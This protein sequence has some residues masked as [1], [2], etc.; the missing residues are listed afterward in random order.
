MIARARRVL[1][2]MLV[3]I[4]LAGPA[5]AASPADMS[6]AA[7]AGATPLHKPH[8]AAAKHA[9]APDHRRKPAAT[10]AA[11]RSASPAA[12]TV[13]LVDDNF[14]FTESPSG[15]PGWKQSGVASWYG[16]TRWQGHMT[17]RGE[18]YDE[19]ALTAAHATLPLGSKV[20]VKLHNSDRFV[21]VT[22]TDRPGT[23]VRIIDLS[24]GAARALGIIAQGV[25]MVTLTPL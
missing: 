20:R 12:D 11:A 9:A 8:S 18:R 10:A 24:T 6:D 5:F 14:S 16:G 2:G 15:Q 7:R 19:N 4:C 17:A 21:D 23:R 1:P 3:S 25:A 22:I 13:A